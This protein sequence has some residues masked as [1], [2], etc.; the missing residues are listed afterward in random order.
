[1]RVNEP[2]SP[3]VQTVLDNVAESAAKLFDAHSV[4]I[5]LVDGEDSLRVAHHGPLL[6]AGVPDRF[7]L[8]VGTIS[9]R[10]ILGREALQVD[11]VQALPPG[12]LGQGSR[13]AGWRTVL[14][15]P[16]VLGDSVVGSVLI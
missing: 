11:D 12:P 8:S 14:G 7:P 1:M 4:I 9:A 2:L 6:P 5:S 3:E 16:L 15:V 13:D 10:V